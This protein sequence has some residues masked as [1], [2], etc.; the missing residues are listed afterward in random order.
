TRVILST[1]N[2]DSEVL[3][4]V[5]RGMPRI[6]V[7]RIRFMNR[8][9]SMRSVERQAA[10]RAQAVLCVSDHD[11]RYFER[12]SNRVVEVPNG[13]DNEF[14]GVDPALPESEDVVFIGQFDYPPNDRGVLRFLR[15]G[16][17]LVRAA[18]PRARLLLAG[19]GMTGALADEAA[20][21]ERVE[22]LGFVPDAGELLEQS[23]LVLVPLWQGGGTRLEVL[24]A[25]AVARP[26]AVPQL[27][28]EVTG[29]VP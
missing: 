9:L 15:E 11:Q 19:K 12:Y 4:M 3:A 23:R 10:A 20:A 17:P 24:A 22:P 14:F 27:E 2:V 13:V 7:P 21:A 26:V 25:L 28:G 18:C 16:W 8:S 29:L 5:A 1:Q 6:S